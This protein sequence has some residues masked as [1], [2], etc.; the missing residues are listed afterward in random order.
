MGRGTGV[1]H[2]VVIVI[3]AGVGV[4]LTQSILQGSMPCHVK[5][6]VGNGVQ[7]VAGLYAQRFAVVT[8]QIDITHALAVH[9]TVFFRYI[10]QIAEVVRNIG[11]GIGQVLFIS[12]CRIAA[13]RISNLCGNVAE[14]LGGEFVKQ[15]GIQLVG[16]Q[17]GIF[18][19]LCLLFSRKPTGVLQN[20]LLN[21]I[22][23]H[24]GLVAISHA[25][26][27]A[28]NLVHIECAVGNTQAEIA[29]KQGLY[30]VTVSALS[31]CI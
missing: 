21:N 10:V 29:A 25:K 13:V 19:D 26:R 20:Q 6:L 8:E 3:T 27:I 30:N 31:A 14:Q 9:Q 12:V 15:D 4:Q 2:K 17:I 22:V 23:Y 24:I 5:C 16:L 1:P 11:T 7:V 18:P 28:D